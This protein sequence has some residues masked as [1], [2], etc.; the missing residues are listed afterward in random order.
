MA[1]KWIVRGLQNPQ[2]TWAILFFKKIKKFTLKGKPKWNNLPD[3]TI[4]ASKYD[5]APKGS[6]L[7]FSIWKSWIK[8][9][10][11]V[12]PFDNL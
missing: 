1:A 4:W 11:N 10:K 7:S 5:I 6:P 8:L 12:V 9:K 3:I 2:E